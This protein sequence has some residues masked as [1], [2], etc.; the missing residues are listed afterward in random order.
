MRELRASVTAS[1]ERARLALGGHPALDPVRRSLD[2][3]M[4][5]LRAPMTVALVG[6]VSC[7]K[8]TLVN[9]LLGGYQVPTGVNELTLNIAILRYGAV[10]GLTVHYDDGRPPERHDLHELEALVG[11]QAQDLKGISH[12]EVV[13]DLDQLRSFDLVDTVGLDAHFG[14]ESGKTLGFLGRTGADVRSSSLTH[15]A[16]ADAIVLAFA[17]G[18]NLDDAAL[19]ADFRGLDIA[20]LGPL[21]ALGVLNKVEMGW[22]A[23][24]PDPFQDADR[25]AARLM[26]APGVRTTMLTILPVAGLMA[27]AAGTCTET[28]FADLTELSR[29]DPGEL[30]ERVD[31]GE[32]F[33]E[34]AD[35]DVPGDR[36]ADLV[37][38]FSEFGVVTACALIRDGADLPALRSEL[39]DRSRLTT[40]RGLLLDHFGRRADVIKTTGALGWLRTLRPVGLPVRAE[41]AYGRALG[42]LSLMEARESVALEQ[43]KV[44]RDGYE[45]RLGLSPEDLEESRRVLGE[46]GGVE[47][48]GDVG[49]RVRYWS[50]LAFH[51]GFDVVTRNAARVVRAAYTNLAQRGSRQ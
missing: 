26:S 49:D 35:I 32:I 13:A 11:R 51:P 17:R 18:L 14:D 29:L 47:V 22:S 2:D 34:Y 21:N 48:S 23:D 28:D 39:A 46:H 3:Q 24:R 7:G 43:L 5:K 50:E 45:G 38:R 31:R 44:L 42:E 6:R 8:S 33:F 12:L 25:V 30:A 16:R 19:L 36:R 9:A 15:A 27:S 41:V 1:F 4:A 20:G 10:P 40:L 37:R